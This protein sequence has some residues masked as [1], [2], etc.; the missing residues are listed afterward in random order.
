MPIY[1]L[2][3]IYIITNTNCSESTPKDRVSKVFISESFENRTDSRFVFDDDCIGFYKNHFDITLLDSI[4]ID[5]EKLENLT[6]L[7]WED[8]TLGHE[9]R[10][11]F[12]IYH[13]TA[14]VNKV[15]Y[16]ID[17]YDA[18][19]DCEKNMF[20]GSDDG[21]RVWLNG[22]MVFE[23][24]GG[25]SEWPENIVPMNF[26][27]GKNLIVYKVEQGVGDWA[28]FRNFN[29]EN[30]D[31]I[32]KE[33]KQENFVYL[34]D[35]CLL[36]D[37]VTKLIF[38]KENVY[39]YDLLSSVGE[40][41]KFDFIWS[42]WVNGHKIEIR[43]ERGLE[44]LP[45]F[46][47]IPVSF[48]GFGTFKT[49]LYTNDDTIYVEEIP[50]IH[51]SRATKMI[52]ALYENNTYNTSKTLARKEAL[53]DLFH[54]NLNDSINLSVKYDSRVKAHALQDYYLETENVV[55]DNQISGPRIMGFHSA[56][57]DSNYMYRLYVPHNL[58]NSVQ[59]KETI[60]IVSHT[61]EEDIKLLHGGPGQ[62]YYTSLFTEMS[63]LNNILIVATRIKYT[64]DAVVESVEE[65]DI[66]YNDQLKNDF[67][68]DTNGISIYT[69]SNG[70]TLVLKML[71]LTEV[72]VKIV[73]FYSPA[74]DIDNESLK[75]ILMIIKH[76]YPDIIFYVRHGQLDEM[77]PVENINKVVNLMRNIGLKVDYKIIKYG[78]HL[79]EYDLL[80]QDFL[81][82]LTE[83]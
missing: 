38:S 33:K 40:A 45:E 30:S 14:L 83:L 42:N 2:I 41:Y 43:S 67:M 81:A 71:L 3:I 79:L 58:I 68:A 22:K 23:F 28:L 10:I 31:E 1:L 59:K 49:I 48:N 61:A 74:I 44:N 19:A 51:R 65:I 69:D 52:D 76:K 63:T 37:S 78:R 26:K 11:D 53:I 7:K 77:V 35:S 34:P 6:N 54:L 16:V 46:I 5:Q 24:H 13:D 12:N 62:K 56:L 29:I 66:I 27:K 75:K 57:Y 8:I 60:F 15:I 32:I 9:E 64:Q 47:E 21:I 4:D 20:L 39:N 36:A 18:T 17:I 82:N 80:F 50:I 70:A 73:G 55:V 25:R 72:P